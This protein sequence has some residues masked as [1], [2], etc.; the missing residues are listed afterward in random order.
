MLKSDFGERFK[1]N[2]FFFIQMWLSHPS[3]QPAKIP[4]LGVF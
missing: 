3:F 2:S 4:L 1:V